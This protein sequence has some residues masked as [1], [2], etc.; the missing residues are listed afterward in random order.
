LLCGLEQGVVVAVVV[1]L[2]A[3]MVLMD[4]CGFC[5]VIGTSA[6]N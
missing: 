4:E 6:L 3:V 1:M 2:Y 5:S